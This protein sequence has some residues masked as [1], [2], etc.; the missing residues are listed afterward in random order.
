MPRIVRLHGFG[1]PENLRVEEASSPEPGPGEVRLRVEAA[2]VNRDHFTFMSGHQFSGHGFVAP[3][4]PT[5]LGY[6]VVVTL[7]W[8]SLV[9]GYRRLGRGI[10]HC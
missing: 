7:P 6:E 3:R 5:R 2:G 9:D 10:V 1:G 8:P 4:L